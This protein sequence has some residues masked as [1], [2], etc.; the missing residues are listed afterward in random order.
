MRR[1]A[2]DE[3]AAEAAKYKTRSAFFRGS[4]G[5]YQSARNR[6]VLDK[7]CAHMLDGNTSWTKEMIVAE[8]AKYDSRKALEQGSAKAYEAAK[9]KG[10][11]DEVCGHMESAYTYW[12]EDM[13]TAAAA[14]HDSRVDFQRSCRG[15]YSAA[16]RMGLLDEVC[17]HMGSGS[18]SSDDVIYIWRANGVQHLGRS[19]YKIGVTSARLGAERIRYVSNA[20]GFTPTIVR[21]AKVTE[22]ASWI[23]RRLLRIGQD[24][25]F[26]D[27]DGCTEFRALTDHEVDCI[28]YIIDLFS[29]DQRHAAGKTGQDEINEKSPRGRGLIEENEAKHNNVH[30]IYTGV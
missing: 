23:E 17:G 20:S 29:D 5:A 26:T 2:E 6:G 28:G 8:A 16:S 9:R 25:G 1:W 3:L 13:I 12:T 11:L 19:V 27:F 30:T 7:V 10:L 15:A 24:P 18:R 22:K 4:S 21:L 14:K